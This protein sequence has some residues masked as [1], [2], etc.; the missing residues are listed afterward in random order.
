VAARSWE[1]A[2]NSEAARNSN[3]VVQTTMA[4]TKAAELSLLPLSSF[5]DHEEDYP[6]PSYL[7]M[8]L[9]PGKPLQ[10]AYSQ[11]SFL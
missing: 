4:H 7:H 6:T 5:L 10:K 9:T 3:L 8:T 1:E 11:Y 2:R